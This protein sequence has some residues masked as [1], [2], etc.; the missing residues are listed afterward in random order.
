[1]S[2]LDQ[3]E[4]RLGNL[5][6][7]RQSRELRSAGHKI[8]LEP[9]VYE[10]LLQMLS[11]PN[12]L[13][14]RDQLIDS[15]WQ[16]RVVSDSAINR[17][18]SQLRK[19]LAEL[20][21][22]MEYIETLPKLGYRLKVV[23][24][25]DYPKP[26][27]A[28]AKWPF[29]LLAALAAIM[30]IWWQNGVNTP[31]V[32]ERLTIHD[33]TVQ[34]ISGD[35]GIEFDLSLSKDGKVIL[36]HKPD[37]NGRIQLWLHRDAQ[38][39]RFSQGEADHLDAK[40]SPGGKQVVYV[41]QTDSCKVMLADIAQNQMT[42]LPLFDCHPDNALRFVWMP[43]SKG[44][45]Y[46]SRQ[47]KT[48]PFAIYAYRLDTR[49]GRQLTLPVSISNGLGDF[50][51]TPTHEGEQLV[52]ATYQSQQK[53]VLT[54]Y[55]T[56]DMSVLGQ[57][58]MSL[59]IKDIQWHQA[60]NSL[61]V[62]HGPYL[63]QWYNNEVSPLFYAGQPIQSFA[64]SGQQLV[65]SDSLQRTSIWQMHLSNASLE[66]R[67]TSS[68]LDLQPRLS[69]DGNHMAF[70]STRQGK[71]QIWLQTGLSEAK[72]LADLPAG[73][74]RLSWQADNSALLYSHQGGI[75]QVQVEDG[76]TTQLLSEQAQAYVV[77]PGPDGALLYSSIKS[78]DWQLWLWHP[79]SGHRQL[80]GQGGYSGWIWAGQLFY[81]KYHQPGLWQKD[82]DS[83]NE[84]LL[85]DDFSVTNWL[86]WQ[87]MDGSIVYHR[88]GVGLFDFNPH[89]KEGR[90]ILTQS[91]DFV[92]QYSLSGD[93]LV[94]V[95]ADTAQGDIY[96]LTLASP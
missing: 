69:H 38:S 81:S 73:F 14:S 53:T 22:E 96:R 54:T 25:A 20:D 46:R 72:V 67:I 83:G 93:Q 30:I 87:L 52:V 90:Q 64:V 6:L 70:I 21:P 60:T 51:M 89:T 45:Y 5:V 31:P 47:D 16:G 62:S 80:T 88:P 26:S 24:E 40:L 95:R 66:Q 94:F 29:F 82:L 13:V 15:V 36:F 49:I 77:N 44:F 76:A 9:R 28:S 61:I 10:L 7:S 12:Y 3:E 50:A 63:Y 75:Y 37:A 8:A 2:L 56:Q 1:M 4:I 48:Q 92:H 65:Y 85:I 86:N 58:E 41:Q 71:H 19:C 17:A 78:G 43:D 33:K 55:R 27:T 74:T 34:P 23:P 79:D 32:S 42:T 35:D 84:T 57:K 11:S 91:A 68:K 59:G 39:Y 18:I